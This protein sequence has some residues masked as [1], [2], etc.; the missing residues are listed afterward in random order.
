MVN[1]FKVNKKLEHI[2]DTLNINASI[3][4]TFYGR[5]VRKLNMAIEGL[6]KFVKNIFKSKGFKWESKQ[7]RSLNHIIK[8]LTYLKKEHGITTKSFI[9]RYSESS[10]L[11]ITEKIQWNRKAYNLDLVTVLQTMT[12]ICKL[13]K[14]KPKKVCIQEVENTEQKITL[15]KQKCDI[16]V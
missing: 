4:R 13:L 15:L 1:H 5:V 11:G 8:Q 3:H 6:G 10:D 12:E 7:E 9:R 2:R 16:E 14:E